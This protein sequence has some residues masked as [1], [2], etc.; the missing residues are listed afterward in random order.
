MTLVADVM[1]VDGL[2][3]LV[4]SLWGI[5]LVTIE[6]YLASRTAKHLVHTLKG[7]FRIYT[8]TRFVDQTVMMDM[9]FEKLKTLMPHMALN[10]TVSHEHIGEIEWKIKVIKEKARGVFN[11]L[12]YQKL[13]KM[14]VIEL[15]HF[16][17]MW[18]K[19]SIPRE[20]WYLKKI[21]PVQVCIVIQDR[22]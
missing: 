21:E 18:M 22:H 2:A 20:V 15:L 1:L 13:P 5:C 14:I 10:T 7:V 12:P 9:E 17:V 16:C 4:T 11:T 3:F 6:R 19:A 8:T